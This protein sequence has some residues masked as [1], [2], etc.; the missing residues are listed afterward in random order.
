MAD[1]EAT[2]IGSSTE[3]T[4]EVTAIPSGVVGSLKYTSVEITDTEW[5]PV[6]PVADPGRITLAIQN[7][8]GVEIKV[9]G[10]ATGA[11]AANGM[12]VGASGE[13]QYQ[14]AS[15]PI[16]YVRASAGTFNIN[17]EELVKA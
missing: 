8:S 17:V 1:C 2:V 9:R 5:R 11:Y 16:V 3:V 13:R 4:G 7:P 14:V 15:V 10:D 12:P 6:P